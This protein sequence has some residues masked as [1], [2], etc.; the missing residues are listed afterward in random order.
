MS[1][2]NVGF[3]EDLTK[4]I[5]QLWRM[6]NQSRILSKFVLVLL[7]SHNY[8]QISSNSHLISSSVPVYIR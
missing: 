1:P 4:I 8:H 6:Q 2:H 5:F 3:Y 7:L